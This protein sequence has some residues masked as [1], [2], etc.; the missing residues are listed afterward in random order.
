MIISLDG[1]GGVGEVGTYQTLRHSNGYTNT[2][3]QANT[4]VTGAS[5]SLTPSV[6]PEE[7]TPA[8]EAPRNEHRAKAKKQCDDTRR[9]LGD[10]SVYA[11][12]FGSIGFVFAGTLLGLEI[13][14]AFLQCFPSKW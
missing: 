1:K 11:Y 14:W 5:N 3:A 10:R 2:L 8:T 13:V 9:Q 6:D 7:L 12:Y 4:D